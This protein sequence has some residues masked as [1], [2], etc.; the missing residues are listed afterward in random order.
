MYFK[1]MVMEVKEAY[2][3][4][5]KDDGTIIRIGNKPGIEIGQKIFFTEEDVVEYRVSEKNEKTPKKHL[6]AFIAVA[7]AIILMIIPLFRGVIPMTKSYAM[8]T[9]DI[10]PSLSI[11]VDKN[12]TIVKVEGLN[13][14]AKALDLDSLK[15][16]TLA[17]GSE[18]LRDT[19]LN[20]SDITNKD[21]VIVGFA[22][23]ESTEDIG[24]EDDIKGVLN[25]NFKDFNVMYL[26]G[27]K[28]DLKMA[29]EKGVSLGKYEAMLKLDDDVLEEELEKLSVPELMD[30]LKEY[31][32]TPYLDE[33]MKEEIQ[34]ELEDKIEDN[35][36]QDDDSDDKEHERDDND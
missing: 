25:N 8:I 17:E 3:L 15:G 10:N 22:F 18:L 9:F 26:K 27:N 7:A 4:I 35:N 1:G 2:A 36:E 11:K 28:D 12:Q 23:L 19:I 16:K 6:M 14:D 31:S 20:S 33:E 24:F 30:L 32:N 34:D 5:M 29:K 13:D 21:S